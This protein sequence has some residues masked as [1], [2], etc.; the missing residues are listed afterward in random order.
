MHELKVKLMRG[1]IFKIDFEKT[2]G[3]IRWDFME[4]VF[5]RSEGGQSLY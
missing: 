4:E 3:I 1:V 5:T 2:Y